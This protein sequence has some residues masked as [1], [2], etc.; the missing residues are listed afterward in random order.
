MYK[1]EN[2]LRNVVV[3]V[4]LGCFLISGCSGG[5][6][7]VKKYN[8]GDDTTDGIV[9]VLPKT[10]LQVEIPVKIVTEEKISCG[11]EAKSSDKN[12]LTKIIK[13]KYDK[14][15]VTPIQVPDYDH[16]YL[17]KADPSATL[18]ATGS[19]SAT[20]SEDLYLSS[21]GISRN[22]QTIDVIKGVATLAL[23]AGTMG[24]LSDRRCVDAVKA[25]KDVVDK[26]DVEKTA[27]VKAA[28]AKCAAQKGVPAEI[29]VAAEICAAAKKCADDVKA[30]YNKCAADKE[31][32]DNKCAADREAADKC[33]ADKC[34]AAKK[35]ADTC[36]DAKQVADRQIADAK[37]MADGKIADAKQCAA[38]IEATAKCNQSKLY[39]NARSAVSTFIDKNS[40][41]PTPEIAAKIIKYSSG[42][43]LLDAAKGQ[44]LS[45]QSDNK[46]INIVCTFD[47][48]TRGEQFMIVDQDGV[49]KETGY[50]SVGKI[51][52]ENCPGSEAM[53]AQLKKQKDNDKFEVTLDGC[54]TDVIDD[55]T[56]WMKGSIPTGDPS[57]ALTVK[58][59][60]FAVDQTINAYI[61]RLP[62]Y[63]DYKIT[64]TPAKNARSVDIL[65]EGVS[66]KVNQYGVFGTIPVDFKWF[67]SDSIS[68]GLNA[69]TGGLSSYTH[70]TTGDSAAKQIITMG[71]DLATDVKAFQTA[72]KPKTALEQ[73]TEQNSMTSAEVTALENALKINQ[74]FYTGTD[75]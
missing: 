7:T 32:A 48:G 66:M 2:P 31:I 69:T 9:Y 65:A 22:D 52:K 75:K 16:A 13:C 61:Y 39:D 72:N 70:G 74:F 67:V 56:V 53:I 36:T 20:L 64:T 12:T 8:Y 55:L 30:V 28:A 4:I 35:A 15:N 27:A 58:S 45:N 71:N 1:F 54:D 25:V 3:V 18:L 5:S 38:R 60:P 21:S 34:A 73:L 37:Q 40:L 19:F 47:P 68:V 24:I 63:V 49:R 50:Y 43:V 41:N 46:T 26:C 6:F 44:L 42:M 33:T 57:K 51:T 14:V 59:N 10:K 29:C 17:I 11:D 62:A 23:K